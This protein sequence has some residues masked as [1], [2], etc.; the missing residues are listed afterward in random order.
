MTTEKIRSWLRRLL[1]AQNPG[2]VTQ[3][4][5]LMGQLEPEWT[6]G[7]SSDTDVSELADRLDNVCRGAS[8]SGAFQFRATDAKGSAM[9]SLSYKVDRADLVHTVKP[10]ELVADLSDAFGEAMRTQ[11]AFAALGLKAAME[12][13]TMNIEMAK[14]MVAENQALRGQIESLQRRIESYWEVMHKLNTAEAESKT[15]KDKSERMGRLA[16][17]TV[18]ALM[19]R[20]F[21]RATPEGQSIEFRLAMAL[22]RSLAGD[23]ERL[24]KILPL[25]TE[26]ERLTAMEAHAPA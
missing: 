19:A 3:I 12:A 8:Y 26:D 16:E 23:P 5:V 14:R 17:T 15:E 4:S 25:L 10:A 13:Q 7:V 1:A 2:P 9:E 20:M 11:H 18:T 24:Q 6:I 22:F 21:G